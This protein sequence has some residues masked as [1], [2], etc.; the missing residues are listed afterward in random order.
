MKA[1]GNTWQPAHRIKCTSN[2]IVPFSV[3]P[4][5]IL[6]KIDFFSSP[7]GHHSARPGSL[8]HHH[9]RQ[10]RPLQHQRRHHHLASIG[11]GGVKGR[12]CFF[13]MLVLLPVGFNVQDRSTY[14][15]TCSDHF[16]SRIYGIRIYNEHIHVLN[17][18]L[19]LLAFLF[20][21]DHYLTL[22]IISDLI[23]SDIYHCLY[24][25]IVLLP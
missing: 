13:C 24:G 21:S 11:L 15:H 23:I 5:H 1:C 25:P 3:Y 18:L 16:E 2:Q 19:A 22:L 8:V 10:S 12:L 9:S 6:S 7:V 4:M 17:V 14:E 20:I